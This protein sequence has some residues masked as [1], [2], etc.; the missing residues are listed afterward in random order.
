MGT[1]Y[2]CPPKVRGLDDSGS[3][4]VDE[5]LRQN[6]IRKELKL[7]AQKAPQF[8]KKYVWNYEYIIAEIHSLV[9][10]Q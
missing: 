7:G 3:E 4:Q 9:K 10:D 2:L 8:Y 5:K 1:Q 6:Q